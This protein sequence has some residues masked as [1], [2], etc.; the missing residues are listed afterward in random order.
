MPRYCEFIS[1]PSHRG[2]W[3]A[4]C[5][6]MNRPE[7]VCL[8]HRMPA[9]IRLLLAGLTLLI[10]APAGEGAPA[11]LRAKVAE[12]KG[13]STIE[14]WSG[15]ARVGRSTEA[16]PAGVALR[17]PG[18]NS[19]PVEFRASAPRAGGIELGPAKVG[20]LTLRL[21]LEQRTP[22][23]V[24]QVLEVR[25]ETPQRFAV[26]FSLDLALD[27]EF[28]TFSGPEKAR[29]LYDT[30][31][32][33]SK[34]ET[35]PVAMVRTSN[36]V[37]GLAADSP[38]LWE[39]RCQVLLDPPNHR[40]AILTGDGRDPYPLVIKPPEDARDTYQYQMDGWQSLAAG[41]TRRF[42]TWVFT[43][44]AR[45]HYDAQ[46]AAHLAVANGKGWNSS[47]VEAI[48]R[49]TSLYLL[50]RN[51]ALDAHNQPRDGRYIF[52]SGPGYGWKQW[53]SDGFYT[54]LGLDDPEKTIESNRA[55]F[56]TRMD[57]EE[58]AQY[59][60]IWAVLMK[61]AGGTVNEALVR[62]AY[63]FLRR[64][65]RE[66]LFIPPPLPGAPNSKGWKTYHDV[67]PY[68]DDDSPA[69]NQGFHCGALLAARELG[70]GAT[71]Q[72]IE[73]AIT[74]YRSLFNHE[75]G[76]MPTS[77]MQRDILGQDTLYGAT[78]TY[79]VFGKKLLT[80]A[81]VLTHVR[82]SEKVKTPYGL[83]VISQ[84]DGALLP[85]HSGV[86][87][88]G[89]SWFLNDAAN[90][91]LAGVHG[92]PPAEVDALLVER[93]AREIASAPAFN[94][95]ISTVDGH[96]HGHILYSWNSGYGWLRRE[97]RKRLGQTG[98]DP[99][100][101]AIDRRL[102]VVR[103]NG[104]LRLD[105]DAEGSAVVLAKDFT[106]AQLRRMPR[107]A[108]A[109]WRLL[110]R[111]YPVANAVEWQARLRGPD[112]G[113]SPLWEDPRSADFM[114]MFPSAATV[115]LH[116]SK[117]S[118][119]SPLDFQPCEQILGNG[120]AFPLESFGGRS[121]DGVMPYFNV[122]SQ[123]GGLI[124]ALGWTGDWKTS[125]ESLGE[126]RVKIKAGLQRAHFKLLPKEEVRMPSVL[127]MSYRGDWL[128]GQNQFRRLMLREFTPTN[129]PPME[130]MPVAASVHGLIGFNDTTESNLTAL[131][132]QLA[133]A[134][135]PLDTFWLDAGWNRGGF[136]LGQGNPDPDPVRFPG[137]LGP[138]GAAARAAGL[139]FLAW[140]E[141]E[142]V[143][144]G[145]WLDQE[146]AS[147]LL[148]PS[149]TS[150]ELR[151]QEKDGFRLLDLGNPDARRW[152]IDKISQQIRAAGIAIY[153]QDFNLYP[154]SFWHTDEPPDRMG[155]REIRHLTGLY[156]F[157]D[158]L[159]RRHP[160][161]VLDNCAS[162]G[163]R[164][165]FEMM[166]RCVALW[167]SD[168]CWDAK[169][170]PRNVQTMTHGLSLWLPMH[171][172]GAAATDDIALRSGM[173]ACASFA[174]NFRDPGA[175]EALRRHLARYL[176]LRP[177]FTK[178]Y[179]PLTPWSDDASRLLAFQFHDPAS[180]EGLVQ[181]FHGSAVNEQSARLP[182]RGLDH[183][184]HYTFSNW[185][186]PQASVSF[187]GRELMS[188]G[189]PVSLRPHGEALVFTYLR[190]PSPSNTTR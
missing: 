141:P 98:P 126:G 118:Q 115:T 25:A 21:R 163:R 113:D 96:P 81:Q 184:G 164:L 165:D 174:I 102:G 154:A 80:D 177:L 73:R 4:E 161:L 13:V 189:L 124:V 57:Y 31:R 106:M 22:A 44:P 160:G 178:D 139:R 135:L 59:Y 159:A 150:P 2:H 94:E 149:G 188:S 36:Q 8:V 52:I 18:A 49:N 183:A 109:H 123:G 51:L 16:A 101:E 132:A 185:N 182:L 68:E 169:S 77:R 20:A 158:E 179:Y 134:K 41:E 19:V 82:T 92:L 11:E 93:I 50:R 144:R 61:R 133:G 30:V 147:W 152:A 173:G 28:A 62:R 105:E 122:A 131:A 180:G 119:S 103:E 84:A 43:S 55:V 138:V 128:D 53:V 29:A 99:V 1:A 63:E 83:R 114:V 79:A 6:P 116:W 74:A 100:D 156:E 85:G 76:F 72:D 12:T 24:E 56:W 110:P 153:R 170:F 130:L 112:Q 145:T 190:S 3:P 162:G 127:V 34:I 129:H 181:V 42:A 108:S 26:T 155:L 90:Y 40:L 60:L 35:F 5:S 86:Y 7:G 47:A 69:S 17:L 151:Y 45:T 27:G 125:F 48:L 67:L 66:G 71:D 64:N 172:L 54:A 91:L 137:D 97:I 89:G 148:R 186:D 168:S 166:R 33:S 58:N 95:S 23:L 75:R 136:P 107:P 120:K 32:G 157:L 121:S 87:C 88:Y 143:M 171:G 167:R 187:P 142:R 37:V 78:L 46:M 70:L 104:M 14:Y 140:F 117:G 15:P 65:E 10:L 38:G 175:V 146:H 176:K 39:N 9:A 111:N